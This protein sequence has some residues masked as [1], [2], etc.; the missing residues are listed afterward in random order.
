MP[1]QRKRRPNWPYR[2]AWLAI[3]SC[4]VLYIVGQTLLTGMTYGRRS[5][6][7]DWGLC[8]V[9]ALLDATVAAWFVAVGAS[10]GSFLNVV[11]YRLPLGR[12][13]GGHSGCP[14]CNTPIDGTDNVPVLA[15]IQ[16]R[17][18]C[19]CCRLPISIQ[20]PLVELTVALV[21]LWIYVTEFAS[22]GSN[23]PGGSWGARGNGF[24]RLTVTPEIVLRLGSYLFAISGLI[25]AALIAVRGK[26]VPLK[27]YL[28]S[29]VP[30]VVSSLV[31]PAVIIVKWRV[32]GEL[33][34]TDARLDAVA[35]LLCGLVA[36]LALARL[37]APIVYPGFDPRLLAQNAV[38][39][40][41]RQWMGALGVAGAIVGWQA[42]VSLGWC[43]ALS[44]CLASLLFRRFRD[45]V[46][47]GDLTVWVWFGL[48]LFRANWA[49]L[50]RFEVLP[51]SWPEVIR[52]VLGALG[53]AVVCLLYRILSYRPPL[54]D[55][56]ELLPSVDSSSQRDE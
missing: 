30:W 32:A 49:A 6:G 28:W 11:A 40:G 1:R 37:V 15:W 27:L 25:G 19:R 12:N 10:I 52:Q 50:M 21:F 38:T 34:P 51:V 16:L 29:L 55:A 26:S 47:L 46:S 7:T 48:L 3:V 39:R 9:T 23:L 43:I 17:G 33:S 42:V 56:G 36:G 4:V 31:L 20:Y 41:A 22:G 24:L 53:V 44:G 45:R 54:E 13:I 14:Y 8:L 18:R 5:Y 2:F 35:S